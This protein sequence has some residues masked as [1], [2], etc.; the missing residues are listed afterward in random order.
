MLRSLVTK[1]NDKRLTL[2]ITKILPALK[3]DD[4]QTTI[5][6][7][8]QE[9]KFTVTSIKNYLLTADFSNTIKDIEENYE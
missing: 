7:F 9:R 3:E 1:K 8:P 5:G 6:S 4:T 2:N